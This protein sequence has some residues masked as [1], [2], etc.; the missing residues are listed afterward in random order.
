V[1]EHE[2]EYMIN[3]DD[4]T[5]ELGYTDNNVSYLDARHDCLVVSSNRNKQLNTNSK[6]YN[7]HKSQQ[8][9]KRKLD[10]NSKTKGDTYFLQIN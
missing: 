10:K 6:T 9:I 5:T 1:S 7:L 4:E 8:R 3:T 2:Q